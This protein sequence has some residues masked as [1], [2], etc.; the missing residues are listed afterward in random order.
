MTKKNKIRWEICTLVYQSSR[1]YQRPS[2]LNYQFDAEFSQNKTRYSAGSFS[3]SFGGGEPFNNLQISEVQLKRWN[4]SFSE[5]T[6]SL[7]EEA[8]RISTKQ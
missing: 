4:Q 2:V 5:S 6:E 3:L 7:F 8:I 1:S